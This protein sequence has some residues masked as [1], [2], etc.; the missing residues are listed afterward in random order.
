MQNMPT[1][2]GALNLFRSNDVITR[3]QI[4][5]TCR[6]Y[7]VITNVVEK[8]E[9]MIEVEIDSSICAYF[10][11]TNRRDIEFVKERA[12]EPAIFICRVLSK[13]AAKAIVDCRTMLSGKRIAP[14]V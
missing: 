4:G 6:L 8:S 2:L 11:T 5:D 14:L 13:D 10:T 1:Q 9:G 7:G 12:F 3:S